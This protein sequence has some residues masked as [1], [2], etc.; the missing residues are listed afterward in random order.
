MALAAWWLWRDRDRGIVLI[1]A[2]L[3][4]WLIESVTVAT[5]QWMGHQAA[6][7]SNVATMGGVWLFVTLTVIGV[8]PW[9]A[10]FR[11]V[12]R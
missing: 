7:T 9:A 12:R 11:H 1:G 6:P 10:F 4:M 3:T 2:M 5:D 8:V